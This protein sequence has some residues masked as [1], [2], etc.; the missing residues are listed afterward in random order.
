MLV[1][2]GGDR[3]LSK[4]QLVTAIETSDQ[5]FWRCKP[6]RFAKNHLDVSP[7]KNQREILSAIA[8]YNRVAVRSRNELGKI[9]T[10]ATICFQ[11]QW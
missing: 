10:A 2:A 8:N 4:R 9:F 3:C 6:V 7:R 1:E 11:I 5:Q